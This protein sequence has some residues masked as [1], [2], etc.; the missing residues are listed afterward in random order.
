MDAERPT[1]QRLIGRF[2]ESFA[3]LGGTAPPLMAEAWA[4]LVHETMSG[5]GRQ[6][7]TVDHVFDI[8]EGASPLAT[9]SILFHDTVY[10]QADGGL[11]PQLETRVGDAV[12][13]EDG[14]VKLAPLDPEGDPLRSMVAGLF[15]FESG[16]TLS[17]YAGLN[18]F[19]SALLAAREIGDHLPRSTVAQVAA[20][21]EATIPF[22]PVGADGVG[23]LQR[24]HCRL[25]GV[26]TAYGLGLDDAAME[27]CVVQAA[28]VANRDVGN[29]ASTDPTVFLD[30]TWKLLPETNNALRGQ[31]LYTVTDY[32]LAIEKMA[33]FLGFLDPGVVF[34]GFA[35]Q[36]EAGVLER[37]TAQAGEN[38]ALGVHYLRAKLLAARVVEALALHT[39]G[40]APIALFMGDLPE[41]GR[42]A[43]KRLEDYL[44]TSSVEPAPSADLT[45]LSLLETGR[46][47]RSGFD[48]KTSPLAAFLYRQ[49]GDEGVQA[50]LETAK[51]MDDAKAWLDSLPEALV[52]AVA[53]ASAEVAVS[54]RAGLL[55]LA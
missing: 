7:H 9:L 38:I 32:R 14:A 26:N 21:I 55:A 3:G 31:R 24:L 22:R 13:E 45:V 20:C 30:N 16:V 49:L 15:G 41:P 25:A 28:D 39:G 12:I 2:T 29:F 53:K 43:T 40:D 10:Y 34:L 51:S 8:S 48:L 35:G 6:Y 18:E 23:P 27:Q 46:T 5:R 52:G 54:R 36:P 19:L 1:L 42:P 47:L 17:P 11:L 33:G 44:P 37:M 50:H 4:V